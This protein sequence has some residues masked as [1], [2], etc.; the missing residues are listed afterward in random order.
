MYVLEVA[1]V[2]VTWVMKKTRPQGE[3][4][5]GVVSHIPDSYYLKE[6]LFDDKD[7][8]APCYQ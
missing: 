5:R 3:V 6:A 1:D 8:V 2:E 7:V 4:I